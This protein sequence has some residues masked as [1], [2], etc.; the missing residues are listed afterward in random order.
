MTSKI[1]K[2]L[3]KKYGS[4]AEFLKALSIYPSDTVGSVNDADH[5]VIPASTFEVFNHIQSLEL[6]GIADLKWKDMLP[7]FLAMPNLEELNIQDNICIFDGFDAQ[8]TNFPVLKLQKLVISTTNVDF[9]TLAS[10]LPKIPDLF[11]L[12]MSGN[13]L[14][15]FDTVPLN[16][17][18]LSKNP[19][20]LTELYLSRNDFSSLLDIT[21][22]GDHLFPSLE[23][24][25][26]SECPNLTDFDRNTVKINP[27]YFRILNFH[28]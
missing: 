21:P 15:A 19:S 7:I 28:R 1:L 6:V 22:I 23:L 4:H 24:L 2:I 25:S 20:N 27:N 18:Y 9:L 8:N 12:Y 16:S 3:L 13:K 10:I 14:T 26:L 5:S 11:V 17:E